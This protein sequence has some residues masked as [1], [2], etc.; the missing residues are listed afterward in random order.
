MTNE[1]KTV[2]EVDAGKAFATADQ[3]KAAYE[4]ADDAAK[5]VG[6]GGFSQNLEQGFGKLNQ[7]TVDLKNNS[8][9]AAKSGSRIWQGYSVGANMAAQR[10]AVLQK[11]LREIRIEAS[12]TTDPKALRLLDERL[13]ATNAKADALI[14][15]MRRVNDSR[16]AAGGSPQFGAGIINGLNTASASGVPLAAELAQAASIAEQLGVLTAG[17]VTLA[18]AGTAAI[19]AA[20]LGS[21]AYLKESQQRLRSEEKITLEYGRQQKI[22]FDLVTSRFE[23]NRDLQASFGNK[24]FSRGLEGNSL[25]ELNQK[26]ASAEAQLKV[27]EDQNALA[28]RVGKNP[29]NQFEISQLRARIQEVAGAY[30]QAIVARD[31]FLSESTARDAD[32]RKREESFNLNREIEGSK[33]DP[34]ALRQ[35]RESVASIEAINQINTL[36]NASVEKGLEK[37]KDFTTRINGVFEGLQQ[38][39]QTQNPFVSLFTQADKSMTELRKNTFGLRADLKATFEDM[40]RQQNQLKLFEARVDNNLSALD[41]RQQAKT[42][43]DYR[44]IESRQTGRSQVDA[45]ASNTFFS[46]SA[47]IS[48]IQG[49]EAL[50][51]QLSAD[52]LRRS[53]N[54]DSIIQGGTTNRDSL[55]LGPGSVNNPDSVFQRVENYSEQLR[56][57]VEDNKPDTSVSDRLN[58]QL[59]VLQEAGAKTEEERA[60]IDRKIV[61]LAGSDPASLSQEQRN[62]AAAALEREAARRESYERQAL[63]TFQSSLKVSEDIREQNK[64]LLELARRSGSKG[65]D[66]VITVKDETE[67]GIRTVKTEKATQDSTKSLYGGLG[68]VGGTNF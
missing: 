47:S 49:V 4:R 46:S 19:G 18:A 62:V 30:D 50:V 22:L 3:L 43:R 34:Q 65:V 48:L 56:R 51:R 35:L 53:A 66:A 64:E 33:N 25:E 1:V 57:Y 8:E 59:K 52:R 42:L 28:Q 55:F 38:G 21:K 26:R 20:L 11:E 24:A 9:L 40:L 67:T 61:S 31:K 15:K 29:I 17:T 60:L 32:R 5:K 63:A 39:V 37:V 10:A 68:L 58:A 14:N 23:F 45:A 2:F 13:A 36:I 41:L 27:L 44:D 12:R 6:T 7:L 16:L 54:P